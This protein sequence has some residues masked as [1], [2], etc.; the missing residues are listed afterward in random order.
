LAFIADDR[1]TIAYQHGLTPPNPLHVALTALC[2]KSLRGEIQDLGRDLMVSGRLQMVPKPDGGYRPIRIECAIQRLFG[3]T[4]VAQA[5]LILKDQLYPLQLGGGYR[6]GAEIIARLM[7]TSYAQGDCLIKA[8]LCNA[9]GSIR[10]RLIW[11]EI[12][13][14]IPSIARFFRWK[15]GDTCNRRNNA[16]DL[17]ARTET[18]VGQGD[19]WGSLF[20][21]LG[22]HRALEHLS[23]TLEDI[24]TTYNTEHRNARI[25][26]PGSVHAYE[27]DTL[28]RGEPAIMALLAPRI[29]QI[30]AQYGLIAKPEKCIITGINTDMMDNQ[31][32]GFIITPEGMTTLGIPVG[33]DE[34]RSNSVRDMLVKMVPPTRALQLLRP[35]TAYQITTMCAN[36]KPCYLLRAIYSLPAVA[37]Y[38][39]IFDEAICSA[40]ASI[41]QLSL[42]PNIKTRLYLPRNLGGFGMTKHLGMA[43]EKNQII[44]RI[45]FTNFLSRYSP[46]DLAFTQEYHQMNAVVLGACEGLEGDTEI[47][48]EDRIGMTHLS[49]PGILAKGKEKAHIRVADELITSLVPYEATR[50][51]AAWLLSVP[52]GGKSFMDSPGSYYEKFF[53]N[54]EFICAV[55]AKLGLGPVVSDNLVIRI[56]GC[57]KPLEPQRHDLHGLSCRLN[58]NLRTFC[59]NDIVTLLCGLLKKRHPS[60]PILREEFIGESTIH[61]TIREVKADIVYTVGL[62]KFYIDV[63]T[64]DPGSET[65]LAPSI[66]SALNR[67]A[68]AKSR[69]IS[70]RRH[71]RTCVPQPP[72]IDVVPFVIEASG[73]LGPAAMSFLFTVCGTQTYMRSN[74][75]SSVNTICARYT[76]KTLKATRDRFCQYV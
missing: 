49:G 6:S 30:F 59:H 39:K 42:T 58:S 16:G 7:D 26:R 73:R 43:T 21:E 57:K 33:S 74:F 35:K 1:A 51:Q 13:R 54:T 24:E 29:P 75:I 14:R 64:I 31:P 56:C 10:H 48:E 66:N 76:G 72:E 45:I 70:K 5:K 36:A 9:F 11:A 68:A 40:V 25:I 65:C 23:Q 46:R 17:V 69:E 47:T 12:V 55:R 15:Y 3:A 32:E 41:F 62:R 22:F 37:P 71:Y 67:D 60:A 18:G 2:N 38:V 19:P 50:F 52:G 28:I 53:G 4:A 34:F 27:D 44:S 63:S 20:F 8:D 61:G